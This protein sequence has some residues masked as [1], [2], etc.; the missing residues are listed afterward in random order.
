MNGIW[1]RDWRLARGMT[2]EQLADQLLVAPNTVARWERGELEISWLLVAAIV[3]IEIMEL[4]RGKA[5]A[6]PPD[7][8]GGYRR[9]RRRSREQRERE[10]AATIREA[11][12]MVPIDQARLRQLLQ[13][14]HPDRH[15][16]S[17]VATEVTAWLNQMRPARGGGS[18]I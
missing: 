14:C 18:R 4:K 6:D 10:A 17:K 1:I 9:R 2:Q 3:G 12:T 11:A 16:N 5:E 15:G 7:G 8:Q 13:L